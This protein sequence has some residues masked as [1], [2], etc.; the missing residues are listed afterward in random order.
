MNLV[1]ALLSLLLLAAHLATSAW[2]HGTGYFLSAQACAWAGCAAAV[3][4]LRAPVPTLLLLFG[5]ALFSLLL[6]IK[7]LTRTPASD[8]HYLHP[9]NFRRFCRETGETGLLAVLTLSGLYSLV[10]CAW[11]LVIYKFVRFHL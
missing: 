3:A 1:I 11:A 2:R 6:N 8:L 9:A 7:Y 10:A 5:T 4:H